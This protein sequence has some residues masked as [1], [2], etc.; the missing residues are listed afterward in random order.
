MKKLAF[1]LLVASLSIL[2]LAPRAAH[3]APDCRTVEVRF[4][5]SGPPGWT[6]AEPGLQIVVWVEDLQGRYI[7]TLYVTRLVGQF[8]LANRPG[9]G[10]LKTDFKWPYGRREMIFPV[11]AHRRDKRYPKVMMGGACGL[12]GQ[13]ASVNAPTARCSDGRFCSGECEDSTIAY[14]SVVST[15]EPFYCSPSGPS[16]MDALSCASKGTFAKGAFADNF[17]AVYSLYPPR[18][19]LSAY[20]PNHDSPDALQFKTLNDLVVVSQATPTYDVALDPPIAWRPPANLPDGDYALWLETSKESDWSPGHD[21]SNP[22]HWN[23]ADSVGAWDFEGHQFLG[24]PSVVFRVPFR[25]D[26]QGYVGST[27]DYAGYGD[28]SGATG[29]LHSPDGTIVTTRPGSGAG[30]LRDVNGERLRVEVGRCNVVV[31]DGGASVDGGPP[32]DG[33]SPPPDASCGDCAPQPVSQL[34]VEPDTN[35]MRISW[36]QPESNPPPERFELRYHEGADPITDENFASQLRGSHTEPP[37][38]K[39]GSMLLTKLD[40][41]MPQTAYTIAVRAFSFDRVPSKVVSKTAVT[42]QQK[43]TVLHGC[44]VATAAF[45][46]A[47][48][49]SVDVLRRFRDRHLFGSAAGQAFVAAYYATSPSFASAISVDARLRTGARALLDPLVH[50]AAL[51]R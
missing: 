18:A 4:T 45:G 11:W 15:Y 41:L 48:D 19:D 16:R 22:D 50:A 29:T 10:L 33:G 34:T 14:H 17:P 28:W 31:V 21:R 9:E 32:M 27:G 1:E 26:G 44:F 42:G 23:K 5:P 24:Q 6:A 8:G 3:A 43:F 30:R 38:G 35:S 49:H 36:V 25:I 20:D 39:A 40:G 51:L 2:P 47:D 37:P 13:T 7:D 12:S 46:E